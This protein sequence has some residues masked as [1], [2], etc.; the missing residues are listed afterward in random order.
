MRFAA[1]KSE[2]LQAEVIFRTCDLPLRQTMQLSYRIEW[3]RIDPYT[4]GPPE[5]PLT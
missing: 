3:N 5:R 4:G 1:V 2:E